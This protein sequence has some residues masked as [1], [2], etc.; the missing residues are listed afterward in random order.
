MKN[1]WKEPK[2]EK[3]LFLGTEQEGRIEFCPRVSPSQRIS[4]FRSKAINCRMNASIL[5]S[6]YLSYYS[7]I[8]YYLIDQLL[9][10]FFHND[11]SKYI[12]SLG[13]PPCPQ[14]SLT[15]VHAYFIS[16][17]NGKL[18]SLRKHNNIYI[19]FL[20]LTFRIFDNYDPRLASLQHL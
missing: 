17:L 7:L 19:V 14:F 6:P 20:Y 15:K 5:I 12:T 16:L 10:L 4:T 3:K 1:C 8:T 11:T 13:N 2:G 9:S 18:F